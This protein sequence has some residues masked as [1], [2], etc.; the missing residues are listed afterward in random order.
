MIADLRKRKAA[1]TIPEPG[2]D[3][4]LFHFELWERIVDVLGE[5]LKEGHD[6]L[7]E[8][9]ISGDPKDCDCAF[10][11]KEALLTTWRSLQGER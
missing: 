11:A 1:V 7:C 8:Y 2:S 3:S 10:N 9:W 6:P 4:V 5:V